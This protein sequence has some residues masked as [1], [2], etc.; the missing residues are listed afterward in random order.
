M[1]SVV[2]WDKQNG[3][4]SGAAA[5][6]Q[7]LPGEVETKLRHMSKLQPR[8]DPGAAPLSFAQERLWF[9]DQI[10][11]G[12]ASANISRGLKI[13]G[14]LNPELLRQSFRTIVGRHESLRTTFATSQLYAGVDSKPAQLVAASSAVEPVVTDLASVPSGQRMSRARE[15]ARAE[16][17]RPFDLTI[18]PLLRATLLVL[19]RDEHVL[20]LTVHRIV[21][22]ERSL[23][24]LIDELWQTYGAAVRG[25]SAQLPSLPIQLADY[26]AWQRD[27]LNDKGLRTHSNYWQ[28]L[29][30][31]APAVLELPA[32]R[33]R[34]AVQNWHGASVSLVLDPNLSQS[35]IT[36]AKLEHTNLFVTLMT[37]FQILLA[38]YS[39]QTDI[40][41]GSEFANREAAE[42]RNLIGPLANAFALRTDLSDDPGFRDLLAR[43]E[44]KAQEAAAH[45]L[46]PF[47]KLVEEL[48]L[49]RSMSYAPVFQV[50]LRVTEKS[51]FAAAP[52]DL[53][54][55]EFEFERGVSRID[56]TLDVELSPTPTGETP[57]PRG[58]EI[59]CRFEYDSDLFDRET[60]ERLAGHFEVLLCGIVSN[61]GERV[62]ALP[63]LTEGERRRVLYEWNSSPT[64]QQSDQCVHELFEA[65]AD[66]IPQAT[67]LVC[68]DDRLTYSELNRRSNQLAQYLRQ[69]GIGPEVRVG[70]YLERSVNNIVA[71]L[72]I[73]KAGGAYVPIDP[74]YPRDRVSFM[75]ED[76]GVPVLITQKSLA[77]SLPAQPAQVVQIDEEWSRIANQNDRNPA[78]TATPENLAYVIYTSGSTG[79]PKGV[80]VTHKSVT[81][82]FAA[83]REQLGFRAGDVWTTVH[84]SAFDF[85]VWEIWGAL[86]LGGQL[87]IVPLE[88]TQSPAALTELLRKEGVTILNQTPSALRQLLDSHANI[89]GLNLRLRLRLR[90]IVCG[91][92]AL[93]RELAETVG[94]IG[95]PV[96]NFYGPTEST[97][98]ATSTRIE[99]AQTSGGDSAPAIQS[100]RETQTEVCATSIGRPIS[101]LEIFVLDENSQPVPVGVPGEI[102]IGGAGLARGYLHRPALTAERFVPSPFPRSRGERLYRTGDLGRHLRSGKL[103]FLGRLDN[104]VKLRG[105]RIE[106]GEIE[107]VLSQH[108]Q[109]EQAVVII[110]EDQP[111]DKRLVAYVVPAGAEPDD[112]VT[113]LPSSLRRSLA[114]KL[115]EYM[116]PSAFVMLTALPLTP[117]RKVDRRALPKPGEGRRDLEGTYLAPRDNLE[118]QLVN[119]WQKILDVKTVGVKDHFF[120]LGGDS[121]LAVRLFAQIENRF[122]KRLPLAALFQAPTIEQLANVLRETAAAK[123]WSS[124]VAIQPHGSKPPLYCI[125]AAGA[126]VLIYRPLSRHLGLDQP[127][128]ALQAKGLDGQQQPFLHV[129]DMAAHY[130]RELRAFQPEGPYQLLGASFGGL[131]IFEMAHQLLAQG[132]Q[133]GLMAMLNTNC[134]VYPVSRRVRFHL[135]HL[136][137]HGPRFYA[138]AIWQT[139]RRRMGQPTVP[140]AVTIAPDPELSRLVA[141]RRNGDDALVRTVLAILEAEKD[142][143]PRGKIYPGKITLFRAED[144]EPDSEDNRLGW[145]KLAAGGLEVHSVPGTH[146]SIREEPQVAILAEKLRGCLEAV[147]E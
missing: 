74:I 134:P 71:L 100:P 96:W 138:G 102:C 38:R 68:G 112:E 47:E 117:N 66:R 44:Q 26:S 137:E 64:R 136:K 72:G 129:E 106:L 87:V 55:E 114:A 28:S 18:G 29:L 78:P 108:P 113:Q 85:S 22:D 76:S 70:V 21:S 145:E 60:I 82:L 17:Q 15:L 144:A 115:P 92:D 31:G 54:V 14:D 101:G 119:I 48:Q 42:T 142:Y 41:T 16:A 110:R 36:L 84:S 125:H 146:I 135:A 43:V 121:L 7:L 1:A 120:E 61:P 80:S 45:Q 73:L 126:N 3:E 6:G 98:W 118:R 105:F 27:P 59:E 69:S 131:V 143:V 147:R 39:R 8:E 4:A 97:V 139:L 50:A 86:L 111:G 109:V 46:M 89:Q 12:A 123:S 23:D 20:V 103:E 132:Q 24:L 99:V 34:P 9:L 52:A 63:L 140:V 62:S 13:T 11:P 124:L 141:D 10:E 57:V 83:T 51:T 75:L 79:L 130:I 94:T 116:M 32:D 2:E 33:P 90:T 95:I 35:L 107:A 19:D 49:E 58:N 133:V 53:L 5:S 40:V 65:A 30:L 56:L 25:E 91:G 88:V 67:A 93:D 77:A 127:V 122:G 81:H 104:Q 128:Y 37:A